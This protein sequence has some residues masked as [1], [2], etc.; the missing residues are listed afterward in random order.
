MFDLHRLHSTHVGTS[1]HSNEH[2]FDPDDR[3]ISESE[4]DDE[5]RALLYS[6][7]PDDFPAS[8]KPMVDDGQLAQLIHRMPEND[9]SFLDLLRDAGPSPVKS[10]GIKDWGDFDLNFLDNADFGPNSDSTDYGASHGGI[11]PNIFNTQMISNLDH[12]PTSTPCRGLDLQVDTSG[13]PCT[14][15]TSLDVVDHPLGVSQP[16]PT[17]SQQPL[18]VVATK[19]TGSPRKRNSKGKLECTARGCAKFVL[20]TK[21]K[22]QMCKG[23]CVTNGGCRDHHGSRSNNLNDSSLPSLENSA[24]IPQTVG[25]RDNHW[26][27]SRPS[28]AI[29][30]QS[31]TSPA[32]NYTISSTQT[33]QKMFRTE[34]SPA[35]E[36]SWRQK[37][38]AQLEALESKSLKA[39]YERRYQNQVVVIFWDKVHS[40]IKIVSS[41]QILTSMHMISRMAGIQ[42]YTVIS[43]SLHGQCTT[44]PYHLTCSMR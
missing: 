25:D 1:D 23:H 38:Q 40:P 34:M 3:I 44:W 43:Q 10:T 13:P 30:L 20:A 37:K 9:E 5:T 27:L 32:T 12:D 18:Q 4:L 6:L 36:A 21:C 31:I 16:N 19:N 24:T 22:S 8:Y 33:G 42:P 11:L 39:E 7:C 41:T 26:A 28:P 14:E 15:N 2:D 29:P 35:H 17:T